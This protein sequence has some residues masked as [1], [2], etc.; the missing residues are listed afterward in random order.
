MHAINNEI[1]RDTFGREW[2]YNIRTDRW[3]QV[4]YNQLEKLVYNFAEDV[5]EQTTSALI[6]RTEFNVEPHERRL[7]PRHAAHSARLRRAG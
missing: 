2:A 3:D 7:E 4:F 6:W 1:V 5:I